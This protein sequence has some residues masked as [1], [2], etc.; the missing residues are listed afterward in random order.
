MFNID[1]KNKIT[2][3][4]GDTA[5]FTLALSDYALKSGDQVKLTVKFSASDSRALISKTITEFTDGKAVFEF[6][7]EDTKGMEAGDYLYEIECRLSD[8]RI[9]TVIIATPFTLI[10][11]LG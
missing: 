2:L 8:G 6:L 10:A 4:R 5:V 3:V 1:S 9:D 7:E 11:D